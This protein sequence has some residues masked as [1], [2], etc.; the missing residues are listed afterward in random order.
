MGQ[1]AWAFVLGMVGGT[2]ALVGDWLIRRRRS[3]R[4]ER[5]AVWDRI[6]QLQREQLWRR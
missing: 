3:E 1:V 5:A 2:V 6:G 4:E